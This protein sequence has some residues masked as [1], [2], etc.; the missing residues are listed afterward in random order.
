MQ[1]ILDRNNLFRAL[2]QVSRN[3]GAPGLDGMTVKQ[4]PEH[5]KQTWI[6]TRQKVL[7][8][9]Y[10]PQPVKRVFIPKGNGGLRPLGIPTVQDRL[11]Q[12][13]IAQILSEQWEP[14]FHA[15]SFGFRPN[16]SAHQAIRQVQNFVRQGKR[17]TIDMD[18]KSF[19]DEVNHDRLMLTLKQSGIPADVLGLINR[20]LKAPTVVDGK[21]IATIKGVPQGG[22]LSPLL[23]NIV[24]NELDWELHKRQLSFVRYADDFQ[25]LVGSRRS[26]ERIKVSLTHFIK[27]KLKLTVNTEKSAE[28]HFWKRSFLGFRLL[29][30]DARIKVSESSINKLKAKIRMV[31]RRTRGRKFTQIIEELKKSLLGWKAYFDISEVLSPLKDLDKWIRRKLRCYLW[32]QWGRSGYRRLRR[33]GVDR[34]LAWNTA[35]SAHGPWRLS[36]SPALY[37]ALPNRYFRNLGLPELADRKG[38]RIEPPWYVTRMPGGVGGGAS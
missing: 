31:T 10:R 27:C 16:R 26:A 18:L 38:N 7:S 21:V 37:R 5:L 13:A 3:Q 28:D 19:F 22:P 35:K 8:S 20:Y 12:Q 29:K 4:L 2:Q 23:A 17:W 6:A 36:K 11:I 32:K 30:K 15:L 9:S 33:L 34:F 14:K 25:I 1:R 24:L